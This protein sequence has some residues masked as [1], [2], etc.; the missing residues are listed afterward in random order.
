[1]SDLFDKRMIVV[2]GKGGVGRTTVSMI[3]G[4]CAARRGKRTLVC[5]ANAPLRYADLLGGVSL[6]GEIRRISERLFAVNLDP[7][8]A[9]EEY[10]L[11]VLRSRVLHRLVFGSPLVRSFLDAV[12]GLA[13]WAMLGKATYHALREVDGEPEFDLVVFD[14][15]ATGHGLEVLSLPRSIAGSIPAGRMREEAE[16]RVRLISDPERFEVLPVAIPTEMAVNE[17]V[18]LVEALDEMGLAVRRAVVNMVT[19]FEPPPELVRAV[20][21]ARRAGE[22]PAWLSAGAAAVARREA[23]R[24]SLERIESLASEPAIL[25]PRL[26]EGSLDEKLWLSLA[27]LFYESITGPVPLRGGLNGAS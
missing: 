14:S 4:R 1:M 11:Q 26:P 8:A 21:R 2:A 5:L 20:E 10:G 12:P 23:E 25:L 17:T 18:E 19:P 15:P 3:V 24:R 27:R 6:D 16:R 22:I 7:V 9:R 13:E